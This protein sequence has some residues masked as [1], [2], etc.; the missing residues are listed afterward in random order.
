MQLPE[1]RESR[2]EKQSK[3]QNSRSSAWK[4][5]YEINKQEKVTE[6]EGDGIGFNRLFRW[7]FS[8]EMTFKPT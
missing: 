8:Q 6:L 2:S 4:E 1:G 7:G 3:L 5:V